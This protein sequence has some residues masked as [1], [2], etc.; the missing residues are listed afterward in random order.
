MIT[1]QPA[2]AVSRAGGSVAKNEN[3]K[4]YKTR[5]IKITDIADKTVLYYD[6]CRDVDNFMGWNHGRTAQAAK[7]QAMI[8]KRYKAEYTEAIK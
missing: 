2:W 6:S 4:Y 5:K 8:G 3:R 7:R 1:K